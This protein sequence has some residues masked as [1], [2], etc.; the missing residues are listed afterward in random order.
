MNKRPALEPGGAAPNLTVVARVQSSGRLINNG[1][2]R[3][4]WRAPALRG[5]IRIQSLISGGDP[6]LVVWQW[7]MLAGKLG[8]RKLNPEQERKNGSRCQPFSRVGH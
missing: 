2:A 8:I 4:F 3:A 1:A 5:L 6:R 7:K